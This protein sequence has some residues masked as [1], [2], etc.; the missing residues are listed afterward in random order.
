[1]AGSLGVV[2]RNRATGAAMADVTV[3]I[4][5][6]GNC[7]D[8]GTTDGSGVKIFD[9]IREGPYTITAEKGSFFI[10]TA[11]AVVSAGSMS[12]TI[13]MDQVKYLYFAIYYTSDDNAFQ[14]AAQT[15]RS[16]VRGRSDYDSSTD[17]VRL[18]EVSTEAQFTTAWE[19][20]LQDGNRSGWKVAEG[21]ILSHAS[22]G[23]NQDGLEFM[24]GGGQDGT[25]S[26]TEMSSLAKLNW[27]A[28]GKLILH[29]CNTGVSGG[30]GWTPAS[31][32][33]K[34]QGVPTTGQAGYAYFS[35]Q[36]STYDEIDAASTGIY[37]WAYRRRRNGWLGGGERM[38]GI[39]FRP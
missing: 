18:I 34:A 22:K 20:I 5:G 15:W 10:A 21:R 25:I 14:R 39:V 26:Q 30:R 16:N 13:Q 33:A 35:K 28:S 17:T 37:L 7:T 29:G 31:V 8:S 1:M 24:G 38:D 3:R 9:N 12:V 36:W 6:P 32:F 4:S 2:V 19:S 27:S 11:N 23:D